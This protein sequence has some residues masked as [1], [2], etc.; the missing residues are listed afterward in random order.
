MSTPRQLAVVGAPL[1]RHTALALLAI[2]ALSSTAACAFPTGASD[3]PCGSS[4]VAGSYADPGPY[5]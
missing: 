1:L 3:D 5:D 2:A 4:Y